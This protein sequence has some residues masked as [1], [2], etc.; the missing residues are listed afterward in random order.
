MPL[1]LGLPEIGGGDLP[2]RLAW[3]TAARLA[4]LTVALAL[5]WFFYL[6]GSARI[7]SF[8]LQTLVTV[9]A[10]AYALAG[11]YAVFLR[12]G[13]WLSF[14]ADAQL[15][16]DQLT[17]T[18]VVYVTGGVT[19]GAT[20]FYGLTCLVG[21][22]LSGF[23]GAAIAALSGGVLYASMSA[24]LQQGVL[25]IPPDQ[26]AAIYELEPG[27]LRFYLAANLFVLLLV[28]LLAGTLA[29]RLRWTG[30]ALVQATERAE[31]AE[32]LAALGRLAT[33]L[34]HEIR[35]PLGSI[36]GS[37]QLLKTAS[38]LSTED[39]E[40]CEIIERETERLNDLVGDMLDL[41]R[42][43]HPRPL[44]V[45]LARV[46]RDVVELAGRSG[47][48]SS[49][50]DVN[51]EGP[52]ALVVE[53]D[54]GMLRQLIWNLVRN[55]VQAS[56]AGDAVRVVV[57]ERSDGRAELCVIDRGLGIDEEAKSRLFDAF[58][59]TRSH[60]TGVG[61]AVVKRIVDDHGFEIGV[62]SGPNQG[63]TFRVILGPVESLVSE[64]MA[65]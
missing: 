44:P 2:R 61:L 4:V 57:A 11:A 43:R 40:L 17:C 15:L 7:G 29:E 21:A 59:T 53:A 51:Y 5:V 30:G 54:S 16:L 56:G 58:F 18:V 52:E 10:A 25:P 62:D 65:V 55:A 27:D 45:D 31:R 35:N 46:A 38:A 41:S 19:S 37:V 1:K 22:A 23:R 26:A 60:G 39:Q 33:G 28:A 42:P 64:T 34:A 14:V 9:L 49:D 47:R 24:A 13:R 48:A 50:V 12:L 63:A 32:R 3:L 8:T 36:S 20:S 6:R